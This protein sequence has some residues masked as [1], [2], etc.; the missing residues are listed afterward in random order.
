M[1][2]TK[3]SEERITCAR[4]R[5]TKDYRRPA[6]PRALATPSS[7]YTSARTFGAM[8]LIVKQFFR[9]TLLPGCSSPP[10]SSP[11]ATP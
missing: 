7:A 2:R 6:V 11:I 3:S 10:V 9:H 8:G 5:A 4:R 1:K